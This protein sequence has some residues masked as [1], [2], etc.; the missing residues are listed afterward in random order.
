MKIDNEVEFSENLEKKIVVKFLF[1]QIILNETIFALPIL[2]FLGIEL[3]KRIME[4]NL[5]SSLYDV[6]SYPLLF[7]YIIYSIIICIF[8]ILAIL[9]QRY[10]FR[11]KTIKQ[12]LKCVYCEKKA[13]LKFIK[14]PHFF[15]DIGIHLC[16]HHSKELDDN[17]SEFLGKEQR[18]YKKYKTII[19]WLSILLIASGVISLYSFGSF[20]GVNG[21]ISLV[22]LIYI[23]FTIQ[24][25]LFFYL[26]ARVCKKIRYEIKNLEIKK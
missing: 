16:E 24:V 3:H 26:H 14:K 9:Y 15:I 2:L 1:I 11:K 21:N 23:H 5:V 4:I 6:L 19:L 10:Y 20:F 12:D 25:T 13:T 22:I 8:I 7:D 18:L 17:P